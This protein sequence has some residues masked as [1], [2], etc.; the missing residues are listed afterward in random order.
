M[1]RKQLK[2]LKPILEDEGKLIGVD[3]YLQAAV[4]IPLFE[5][6]GELFILFEKRSAGIRQG[7]EVSFPGGEIE[8]KDG[9]PIQTAIRETVEELGFPQEKISVITKLGVLVSPR[10]LIVHTY[11]GELEIQSL[12]ELNFSRDEVEKVFSLPVSF[13]ENNTPEEFDLKYEIL[14]YYIDE[15]GNKIE[16][17]PVKELNL[18]P[19]YSEPWGGRKHKVLVYKT[20]ETPIWGLTAQ[21]ISEF[22]QRIKS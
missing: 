20:K 22:L 9:N 15:D 2:K 1:N 16:L 5:K 3:G 6:E 17:L 13:F 10:G 19:R 21:I 11:I 8:V 18:P 12:E 4:L 7:G 14:P